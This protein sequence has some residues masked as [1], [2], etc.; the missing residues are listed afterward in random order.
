MVQLFGETCVD[1]DVAHSAVSLV[2]RF[3]MHD[4]SMR[5]DTEGLKISKHSDKLNWTIGSALAYRATTSELIQL[6]GKVCSMLSKQNYS[7]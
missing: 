2:R 1:C 5:D 6:S 3:I 4:K 7:Q